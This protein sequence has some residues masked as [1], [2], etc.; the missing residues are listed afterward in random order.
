MAELVWSALEL[1]GAM[2]CHCDCL[3]CGSAIPAATTPTRSNMLTSL[4]RPIGFLVATATL[5]L[6]LTL[7]GQD[8]KRPFLSSHDKIDGPLAGVHRVEELQVFA[9]GRVVFDA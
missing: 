6:C 1:D 7:T 2:W 8:T 9:D 3:L 5:T 4:H